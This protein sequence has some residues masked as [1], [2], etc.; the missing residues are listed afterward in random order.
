MVRNALNCCACCWRVYAGAVALIKCPATRLSMVRAGPA[1][2]PVALPKGVKDVAE[3]APRADEQDLLAAAR[4]E[5]AA[6]PL[7]RR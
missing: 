7:Q 1:A 4:L 3:L 6:L 2:V 5:V